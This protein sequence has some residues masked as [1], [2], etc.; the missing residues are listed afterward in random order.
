MVIHFSCVIDQLVTAL[1]RCNWKNNRN[2]N[3]DQAGAIPVIQVMLRVL[4]N[5]FCCCCYYMFK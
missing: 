4:L 1:K 5:L 3:S 2:W